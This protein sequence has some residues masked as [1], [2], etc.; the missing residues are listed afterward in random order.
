[1]RSFWTRFAMIAFACAGTAALQ[2]QAPAG[3]PSGSTGQ[4]K[5]GT[6][7]TA[8]S[9]AG[10]CRGHQGVQSWFSATS[11]TSGA[12][13]KA[14]AAMPAG[15]AAAPAAVPATK[16]AKPAVSAPAVASGPAPAGS[17]GQC[18]DGSY[19]SAASKSGACRGHG[20]VGSW[21]TA[22]GASAPSSARATPPAPAVSSQAAPAPRPM[23]TAAPA[24]MPAPSTPAKAAVQPARTQAAP[25][26]GNGQ[27]WVNTET[28]VYHCST[29]RYYG[30]TKQGVYMSESD[31]QAK[32]YRADAGKAC[33]K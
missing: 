28:K 29:D 21:F 30:K 15:P 27:V 1:M 11:A 8:A 9:K 12:K 32:G 5:D 19:S 14:S 22:T 7:S 18:K 6:Y 4:C 17:T 26:G 25:G 16:V 31:A 10:A 24:P 13:S 20:G 23:P 33:T 2:A 3:A